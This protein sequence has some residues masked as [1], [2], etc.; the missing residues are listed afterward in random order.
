MFK[1]NKLRREKKT[2]IK[3]KK[4]QEN[5]EKEEYFP[6]KSEEKFKWQ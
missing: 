2:R 3:E 6:I 1:M 5:N 4:L